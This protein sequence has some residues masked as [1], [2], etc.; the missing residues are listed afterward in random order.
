MDKRYIP[1]LLFVLILASFAGVAFVTQY[2]DFFQ[3]AA[4][5]LMGT[6]FGLFVKSP[7]D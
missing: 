2:T 1:Y 5:A 4:M 7:V 6:F 3:N